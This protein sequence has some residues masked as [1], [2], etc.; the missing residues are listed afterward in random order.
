MELRYAPSP[1][2]VV[3]DEILSTGS[4]SIVT[5]ITPIPN[6]SNNP[7]VWKFCTG[8]TIRDIGGI[9]YRQQ[10]SPVC[11][12][13]G[14]KLK[15]IKLLSGANWQIVREAARMTAKKTIG[16]VYAHH[17]DSGKPHWDKYRGFGC[18]NPDNA[19]QWIKDNYTENASY[20]DFLKAN[21]ERA[22]GINAMLTYEDITDNTPI[23]KKMLEEKLNE[24]L[25]LLNE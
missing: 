2:T 10:Q 23:T 25:E 17:T 5:P 16:G 22:H 18:I 15:K 14:A 4:F 11:S 19:I 8:R 12:L 13:V 24:I 6:A 21:V 1:I 20:I 3:I 9:G 7:Y